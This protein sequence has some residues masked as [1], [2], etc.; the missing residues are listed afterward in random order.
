MVVGVLR[1]RHIIALL[2]SSDM[3]SILSSRHNTKEDAYASDAK[4]AE[5]AEILSAET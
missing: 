1:V 3:P 4:D 5:D 2:S